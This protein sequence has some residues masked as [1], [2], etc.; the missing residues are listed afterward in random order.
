MPE[1]PYSANQGTPEA[2]PKGQATQL[3]DAV[4]LGREVAAEP[5]DVTAQSQGSAPAPSP[6][7]PLANEPQFVPQSEDD[8]LLF[9]PSAQPEPVFPDLHARLPVPANVESWYPTLVEAAGLPDAPQQV[10]TLVRLLSYHLG[11]R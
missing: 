11:A 6:A 5:F 8:S 4:Q 10:K 7:E 1:I 3:N 9:G 2:L